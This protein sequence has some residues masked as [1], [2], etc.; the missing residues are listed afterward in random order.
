VRQL[1]ALGRALAHRAGTT[2]MILAVAV[3]AAAAAA[4]GPVY[5]QSARISILNDALTS[6]SILSRGYQATTAGA[7][8]G[9]GPLS[10]LRGALRGELDKSLG[11]ATVSRLLRPPVSS[12][13]ATGSY[14]RLQTPFPL[15]WRTAA[16][17]HLMLSGQ[18]PVQAGQ[19]IVSTSDARIAGWHVGSRISAAGLPA[20]TVSGIYRAPS[21]HADY[22][23]LRAPTYF[24]LEAPPDINAAPMFDALFTSHATIAHAGP[25]LQGTIVIQDALAIGRVKVTDVARLARALSLLTTDTALS[26]QNIVVQ[27]TAPQTLAAVQAG[28]RAVR[29]PVILTT[30][31]VLL[32]SW[33][34]LFLIVT[35]SIEA[36]GSEIA[37]ARLRGHGRLGVAMFGLSEPAA[38]LLVCLPAGTLAGWAAAAWLARLML[39]QGTPVDMPWLAWAAAGAATAGGFAAVLLAARRTLRR[40]VV[41]Q[42]RRPGRQATSRGWVAD[43]ILLTG[44]AAGLLEL[45]STGQ[46]GPTSHGVLNLLVPGLLGLAVAVIASRLL[47]LACRGLYSVTSRRG[48]L[49]AFLAFRHIARRPGGVRT[50][51]VLATAFSLAGFAFAAWQVGQDNYRL[52]AGTRVGAPVVLSVAVPQG[53]DLGDI[54][55]QADPGG[56]DAAA[57][58]TYLAPG[59]ASAGAVTLAVDPARFAKVAYWPRQMSERSIAR[60]ARELDPPAAAPIVLTGDALRLTVDVASLSVPGEL[61]YANV[62]TGS[63]PVTLGALPRHGRVTLSAPLTGC[64]CVLQSI[65]LSLSGQQLQAG[66]A[67]STVS[68]S[69]TIAALQVHSAN[70]WRSATSLLSSASAWGSPTFAKS[71]I[72]ASARGLTWTFANVPGK[73]E[74]TLRAANTPERLPAAIA[75]PLYH[76]DRYSL[77][78]TGLNGVPLVMRPIAVLPEVPGAPGNGVLV[79]RRYAE[80]AAG[81]DLTQVRMQIWLTAE[82]LPRVR[83]HL[84]ASGVRILSQQSTAAA[85]ARLERQGPALASVLFLADAA[86]A[87]VLAAVAAILGLYVSARRRRYEYAALEASGIPR[88]SLR[89]AVLLELAVVL[90]FGTLTGAATGLAAARLVLR[91]VPEFVHQPIRPALSY[92]P[93]AGPVTAMLGTA[94]GLLVVAALVSSVTL[95]RGVSGDQLR[96]APP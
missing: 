63:S 12:I 45:I 36:R 32:L 46:A 13:E 48:G 91:S 11:N 28:W 79:D 34:L 69:L 10:T 22:W 24:S 30:A 27:S 17:S 74:P 81:K 26:A 16:C 83:Q 59:G 51:I 70:R 52:V 39:Q 42:F 61:V 38:L 68:A 44:S 85:A 5:Y 18:C 67:K 90:A 93:Q 9:T 49:A 87:A 71:A 78:G 66:A 23:A 65:A 92:L 29:V 77:T 82:A 84:L 7:I 21:F 86:A 1:I 8:S 64:P 60:I 57:V 76:G 62:T 14:Q 96:E 33:M 40:G 55:A 47:P 94:I 20:L 6:A 35:D 25:G 75:A 19:V 43:S 88:R 53:R 58:D 54:V 56:N 41:E 37:L 95:I 2:I 72:S 3:I 31:T 15:V 80:L 50:T 89:S 73:I 4:A